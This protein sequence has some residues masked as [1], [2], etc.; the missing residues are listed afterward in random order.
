MTGSPEMMAGAESFVQPLDV[1]AAV[2]SR[3][4]MMN[5]AV[6][7]TAIN[8]LPA[9]LGIGVLVYGFRKVYQNT[10]GNILS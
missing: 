8:V 5:S 3:I 6:L 4:A 7:G 2:N 9:V 10:L 1:G